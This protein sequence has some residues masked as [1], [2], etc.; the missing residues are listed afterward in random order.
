MGKRWSLILFSVL[1][2]IGLVLPISS[3]AQKGSGDEGEQKALIFD[4]MERSNSYAAYSEKYKTQRQPDV[5][6][7][8]PATEYSLAYDAQLRTLRDFEGASMPVLQWND[9][10]FV[11]WNIDIPQTGIYNIAIKYF[12]IEGKSSSIERELLI[13]GERPFNECR[14]LS[15]SRVWRDKVEGNEFSKDNRGNDIRPGQVENPMWQEIVLSD[16]EGLYDEPFKFYL[17][18]GVHKLRLNSIKEPMAI[19]YIKVF[20]YE[21][22]LPYAEVAADYDGKIVKQS[23]GQFIKIQGENV[24][25]KS[26]PTLY[27]FMD[28]SN[29][30]NEPYDPAKIRL[31]VIGGYN[32]RINGQWITWKFNVTEDGLYKVGIKF[33]Q[34]YMDGLP[35][36]RKIKIDGKVPFEELNNIEFTYDSQWQLKVL[37]ENNSTPYLLY[38]PKGEHTLTMQVCMGATA[39]PIREV[40]QCAIDLTQ[41]Y[42][43]IV[44]LTGVNPDPYRDYQLDKRIKELIPTLTENARI[45]RNEIE[46]LKK[47]Y[48]F[49]SSSQTA[50]LQTVAIQ[51]ETFA[52]KPETISKGLTNF[53]DNLSSLSS[54]SLTVK[55]QPLDIDYIILAS[56]DSALPSVKPSLWTRAAGTARSLL[57]SFTENYEGVGSIYNDAD[58]INVWALLG[59]DQADTLK[60]II[61]DDFT[62]KTGIKVNLD[63]LQREEVLLYSVASGESPDVAL[64]VSRTLPVDYGVRNALVPLNTMPQ[65]DEV[66]SQFTPAS[67]IPY[68]YDGKVFA[69]PQTQDFPMLFYRKDILSELKMSVPETWED[70]YESI[71]ILEEHNLEFGPGITASPPGGAAPM[72]GLDAFNAF[73]LQNGGKYY[74][75]DYKRSALD[76]PEGIRAFEDWTNLYLLYG[77]PMYFDFY[78]RFRTGEMP[79]GIASYTMYNQLSVAAPEIK[80]LWD[81]STLPGTRMPDGTIDKTISG[82]GTACVLLKNSDKKEKGWEFIKWWMS[83]D[84]QTRYGRELEAILGPAAR[85]NTANIKAVERLPWSSSDYQKLMKQWNYLKE[86][87]IIPGSYYTSRH[88]DNAF[89]EVVVNGELPREALTKYVKEI[90]KE[91]RKKREE[92]GLD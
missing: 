54:W 74:T 28:R 24:Y 21:Q 53:K 73:L 1:I 67:L 59:R 83:A 7:V 36:N 68:T 89:R 31:N 87:P 58:A 80:G 40:Q 33:R 85:Y 62:P 57:A 12:P 32:W 47:T 84:V 56:P 14:T 35:S 44:M 52:K 75:D 76:T 64:N 20:Q 11:E 43:K 72:T 6:I 37:G 91:I 26:D 34:N 8:I 39:K 38:L 29:P 79:I 63:M 22:P 27:P 15:F 2:S 81:I 45:I 25:L 16:T 17:T 82:G 86:I 88:L 50:T 23:K 9:T 69:L 92:F 49:E 13:D 18:Q 4:L 66:K 77:L 19:E 3:Y 70:V 42:S 46:G 48:G 41:L 60:A 30:L 71:G 65:F 5:N 90:N 51:L 55:E 78:N 61:E 10:G